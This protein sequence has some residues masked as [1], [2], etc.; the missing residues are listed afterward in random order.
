[1]SRR[2]LK[3]VR[4]VIETKLDPLGVI[5]SFQVIKVKKLQ[6]LSMTTLTTILESHQEMV[7]DR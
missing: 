6:K 2:G 4:Y 1:M 5:M 3:I 7:G